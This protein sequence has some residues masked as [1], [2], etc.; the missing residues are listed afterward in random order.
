M[1]QDEGVYGRYQLILTLKI[2]KKEFA[3]QKAISS[4]IIILSTLNSAKEAG[5]FVPEETF[6][7]ATKYVLS[8]QD[9]KSGGFLYPKDVGPAFPR[10]A[11]GVT[12]L[13]MRGHRRHAATQRGLAYLKALPNT[14]FDPNK[15]DGYFYYANYYAIQAMYQSGN[16]DFQAWYPKIASRLLAT[17]NQDGSWSFRLGDTYATSMAILILG[18]PYR[19]LPIYQR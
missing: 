14:K 9:Q 11:A 2:S 3:M 13:M 7:R 10:S 8:Q 5:I 15:A 12:W 16:A 1:N 17:Q 19:Y 4:L 6:E 18:V